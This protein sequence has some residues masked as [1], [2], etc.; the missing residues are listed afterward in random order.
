MKQHKSGI[1]PPPMATGCLTMLLLLPLWI[2]ILPVHA[3]RSVLVWLI[4]A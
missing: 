3:V 4:S 1:T 2:L